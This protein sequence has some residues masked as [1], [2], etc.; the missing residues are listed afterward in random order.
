M[1]VALQYAKDDRF[2]M[3]AVTGGQRAAALP[4]VP[5]FK[6]AGVGGLGNEID[7]WW[8]V[9]APVRTPPAI[10]QRLDAATEQVVLGWVRKHWSNE[11]LALF[12]LLSAILVNLAG[13]AAG[14]LLAEK[15]ATEPNPRRQEQLRASIRDRAGDPEEPDPGY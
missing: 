3:L 4:Q 6:E 1:P 13:E 15:L 2:A 9:T 14:Q 11:P 10:L 5:T 8:A 7:V 12:E